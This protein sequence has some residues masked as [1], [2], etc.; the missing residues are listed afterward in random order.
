MPAMRTMIINQL[1]KEPEFS[2]VDV[3]LS[4]STTGILVI[5]IR[6]VLALTGEPVSIPIP[7]SVQL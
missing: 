3:Q 4:L 6:A 5:V 1:V 7:A 2:S